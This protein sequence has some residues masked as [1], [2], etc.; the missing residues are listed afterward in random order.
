MSKPYTAVADR[1]RGNKN[2]V[3]TCTCVAS[4]AAKVLV[5]SIARERVDTAVCI[6]TLTVVREANVVGR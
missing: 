2:T 1:S 3:L 4:T 5:S 6:C